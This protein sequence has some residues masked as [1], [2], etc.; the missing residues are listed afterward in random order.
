[1]SKQFKATFKGRTWV[2][3]EPEWCPVCRES[4]HPCA[5]QSPNMCYA[6]GGSTAQVIAAQDARSAAYK[7]SDDPHIGEA[8][9]ASDLFSRASRVLWWLTGKHPDDRSGT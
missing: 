9:G 7:I 2:E 4:E 6:R 3:F 1:M 5:C 8:L